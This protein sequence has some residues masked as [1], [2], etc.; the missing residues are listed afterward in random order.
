LKGKTSSIA[1]E[2]FLLKKAWVN[3]GVKGLIRII[4]NERNLHIMIQDD[5]NENLFYAF[6][7]LHTSKMRG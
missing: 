3:I 6:P 2:T 4:M 7:N 1:G 5:R